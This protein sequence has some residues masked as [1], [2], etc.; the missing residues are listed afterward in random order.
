[1]CVCVYVRGKKNR[2]SYFRSPITTKDK[3]HLGA[4]IL[5]CFLPA[6]SLLLSV[7]IRHSNYFVKQLHFIVTTGVLQQ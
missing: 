3:T 2:F 1:M 6:N 5:Q 4:V 7:V